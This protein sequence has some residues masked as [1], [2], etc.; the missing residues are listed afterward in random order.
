[1]S[2]VPSTNKKQTVS[3]Q[4][5]GFYS[6]NQIS[7]HQ[8]LERLGPILQHATHTWDDH[9]LPSMDHNCLLEII[10][11]CWGLFFRW[12]CAAGSATGQ[13]GKTS[14]RTSSTA[15]LTQNGSSSPI[16]E[17]CSPLVASLQSPAVRQKDHSRPFSASKLIMRSTMG[18]ERLA[19]LTLMAVHFGDTI[20]LDTAQVVQR[21]AEKEPRKLF[22]QSIIFE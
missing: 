2:L 11:L 4:E 21:F 13:I 5:Q 22:C 8:K 12:N 14:L 9:V 20:Q 6:G 18:E 10:L 16:S 19:G 1:M 3:K 17:F 7:H 15:C